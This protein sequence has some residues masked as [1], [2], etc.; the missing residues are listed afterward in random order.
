VVGKRILRPWSAFRS[1]GP[2]QRTG[3]RR[4][5]ARRP[6]PSGLATPV[7]RRFRSGR[8]LRASA[9]WRTDRW[10]AKRTPLAQLVAGARLRPPGL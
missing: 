5:V 6:L 2:A 10:T 3:R 4:E 9:N 8:S 7:S 1:P